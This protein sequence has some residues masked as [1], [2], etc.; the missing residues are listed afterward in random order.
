MTPDQV[1]VAREL[2]TLRRTVRAAERFC[3]QKVWRRATR[4]RAARLAL[5]LAAVERA[6][7][8]RYTRRERAEGRSWTI[9][10]RDDG[11]V[12]VLVAVVGGGNTRRLEEV[13][14]PIP[15]EIIVPTLIDLDKLRR[16]ARAIQTNEETR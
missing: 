1:I 12:E 13:R 6:M 5:V 4:L 14:A 15:I 16:A 9:F 3:R 10:G 8:H 11:D 7:G 2:A